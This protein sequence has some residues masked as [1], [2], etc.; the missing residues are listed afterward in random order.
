MMNAD[1]D[2]VT[3]CSSNCHSQSRI[4]VYFYVFVLDH[5]LLRA[6]CPCF[7]QKPMSC[8]A[9]RMTEKK[10]NVDTSKVDPALLK[11]LKECSGTG[12]VKIQLNYKASREE[13]SF[14][15]IKGIKIRNVYDDLN[16]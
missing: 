11:V 4:L 13:A 14:A 16:M 12:M 15:N 8:Q 9:E 7:V 6:L 10:S 1:T 5:N 2:R 3:S